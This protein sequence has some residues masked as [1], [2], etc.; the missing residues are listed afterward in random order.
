MA[1]S[2]IPYTSNSLLLTTEHRVSALEWAIRFPPAAVLL[3]VVVAERG[4]VLV[5]TVAG[6]AA[7]VARPRAGAGCCA[8]C[9]SNRVGAVQY[10]QF[11]FLY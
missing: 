8:L 11:A 7:G 5:A 2:V 10:R 6:W 4:A 1:R 9:V 3:L